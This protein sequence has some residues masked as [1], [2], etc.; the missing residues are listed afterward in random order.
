M[1]RF[2]NLK[3]AVFIGIFQGLSL[4]GFGIFVLISA[5]LANSIER[6]STLITEVILYILLGIMVLLISK[7]FNNLK[8][9]TF[10]PFVLTQLFVVIIGW[11]LIQDDQRLTQALG[12]L[13]ILFSVYALFTGLLPV[14]RKKFL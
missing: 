14:N 6:M 2:F 7:G 12:C 9:L 3:I 11:P 1:A 5:F 13:M 10:T 4:A 8:R